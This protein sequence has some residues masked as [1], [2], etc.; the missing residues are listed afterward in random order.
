[1]VEGAGVAVHVGAL[2]RSREVWGEDADEFKP[3]RFADQEGEGGRG[4]IPPCAFMPFTAGPR[5]CV[6]QSFAMMELKMMLAAMLA[7]FEWA[8]GPSFQLEGEFTM[9]HRNKHGVPL[10]LTPLEE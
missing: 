10:L 9:I 8:L 3:L 2:H 5:V 1:M 4:A 6:G 7:R